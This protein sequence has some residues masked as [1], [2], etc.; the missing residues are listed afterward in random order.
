MRI[1]I[2]HEDKS[3][4]LTEGSL[5][6]SL[7]QLT[8]IELKKHKNSNAPVGDIT[9]AGVATLSNRGEHLRDC[10]LRA[11]LLS[12]IS[13][14]GYPDGLTMALIRMMQLLRRHRSPARPLNRITLG[15]GGIA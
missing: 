12:S 11:L 2:A 9:A 3:G 5:K 6:G 15:V 8:T 10:E 7:S 1:V 4:K 13:F 14:F